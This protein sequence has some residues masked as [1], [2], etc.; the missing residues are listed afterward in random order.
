[1]NKNK[2]R[3][4]TVLAVIFAVFNLLVFVIPFPRNGVFWV[5]YAF[6]ILPILAQVVTVVLAFGKA[7]TWRSMFLGF[8]IFKIGY[9][10]LEVQA[11]LCA[12]LLGV[13]C[14]V[15]FSPWIA[16][17]PCVL[18][19]AAAIISVVVTDAGRDVIEDMEAK[20]R[21]KTVFISELRA[22]IDSLLPRVT[23]AALNARLSKLAE[24]ARFS[25][26]MSS[27]ALA[28]IETEIG[29]KFADI[30]TAVCAGNF[31]IADAIDEL[32]RLLAERNRKC[33]T[34]KLFS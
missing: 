29:A 22:G 14:Y 4:I 16:V 25:D 30:K 19:L 12:V 20:H 6:T 9:T 8:P 10:Y 15:A 27:E 23:D 1:M 7:T 32:S 2:I 13:S 31:G 21:T 33:K 11:L 17:V 34:A 28:S 18:V 3:V 26:P 5:T 24:E